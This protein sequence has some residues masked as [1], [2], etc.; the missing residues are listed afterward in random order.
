MLLLTTLTT[1]LLHGAELPSNDVRPI[2]KAAAAAAA[3]RGGGKEE[4][5]EGEE[6]DVHRVGTRVEM[7]FDDGV[8]YSSSKAV[9][10]VVK[11]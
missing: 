2:A 3:E 6:E 5:E 8:W 9:V 10:A 11:Q 1:A 7:L 4:E